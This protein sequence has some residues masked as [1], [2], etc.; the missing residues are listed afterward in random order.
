MTGATA[1]RADV[2]STNSGQWPSNR[3]LG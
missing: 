1:S 2:G 3:V